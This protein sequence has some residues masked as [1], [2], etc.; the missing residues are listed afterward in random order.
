MSEGYWRLT[1]LEKSGHCVRASIPSPKIT[2]C[3][4]RFTKLFPGRWAT[5]HTV[6]NEA[7]LGR[8]GDFTTFH[9]P[10]LDDLNL[11]SKIQT[12]C[13]AFNKND[14]NQRLRFADH[15]L[16]RVTKTPTFPGLVI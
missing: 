9:S 15:F 12:L 10:N 11:K 13:Q 3:R 7:H 1:I 16:S 8:Y 14:K 4:R 5:N 6:I 2:Y